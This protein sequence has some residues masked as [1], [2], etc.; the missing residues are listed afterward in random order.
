MWGRLS[1]PAGADGSP[2]DNFEDPRPF[3]KAATQNRQ[4]KRK[5]TFGDF[6]LFRK[7]KGPGPPTGDAS[8]GEFSNKFEN[9]NKFLSLTK[10]C[11]GKVIFGTDTF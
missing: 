10:I 7:V 9:F 4:G 2:G 3:E 5:I 11:P 8:R 6:Q 1:A